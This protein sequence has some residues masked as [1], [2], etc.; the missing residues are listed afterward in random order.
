MK[1]SHRF[2]FI[3]QQLDRTH[4]LIWSSTAGFLLLV[5]A[6]AILMLM[7]WLMPDMVLL[8]KTK[9]LPMEYLGTGMLAFVLGPLSACCLNLFDDNKVVLDSA[10]RR[11]GNE[12]ER[13]LLDA[14]GKVLMLTLTSGK[15]YVAYYLMHPANLQRADAWLRILPIYSGYRVSDSKQVKLTTNYLDRFLPADADGNAASGAGDVTGLMHGKQLESRTDPFHK[16]IRA[17]DIESCSLFD[18]AVWDGFQHEDSL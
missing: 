11:H 3:H 5:L 13:F 7:A 17:G 12:L 1:M 16:L 18:P 4:L 15:V 8:V 6:R 2:S 14:Y 10:I 9:Q